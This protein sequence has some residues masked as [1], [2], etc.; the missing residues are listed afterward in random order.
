MN[1]K[2]KG[3]IYCGK[4]LLIISFIEAL[5]YNLYFYTF[6]YIAYFITKYHDIIDK[7]GLIS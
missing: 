4:R 5:Y 6:T 3:T 2:L 7:I 1:G